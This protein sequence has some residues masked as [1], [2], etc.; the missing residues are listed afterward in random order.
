MVARFLILWAVGFH[1]LAGIFPSL[2]GKVNVCFLKVSL[3]DEKPQDTS[4]PSEPVQYFP[5]EKKPDYCRAFF[6]FENF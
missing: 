5:G 2:S 4:N 1:Q 3:L 6:R